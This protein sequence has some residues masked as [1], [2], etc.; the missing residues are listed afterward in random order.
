[1]DGTHAPLA[2]L[3]ALEAQDSFVSRHVAPDAA[4]IAHMLAAVGAPS[5]AA[6]VAATV[7][8]AIRNDAPLP[9][10]PGPVYVPPPPPPMG[11]GVQP[12]PSATQLLRS[13]APAQIDCACVSIIAVGKRCA[14]GF[15]AAT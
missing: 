6:L 5:L 8:G 2:G 15:T 12:L 11:F 9:L 3:D 14:P 4:G 10:P 7:P 13:R 1:M